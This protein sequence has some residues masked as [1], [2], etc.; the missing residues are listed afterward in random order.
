MLCGF[1]Y[2]LTFGSAG[3]LLL[4]AGSLGC[5]EWALLSRVVLGLLILLASLVD[6]GLQA[7]GSGVAALTGLVAPRPVGCSGAWACVSCI[8]G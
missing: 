6:R 3:S 1:F 8:G 5:S 7:C 4:P 2:L